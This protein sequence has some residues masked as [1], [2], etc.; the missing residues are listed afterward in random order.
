MILSFLRRGVLSPDR[1]VHGLILE[2]SYGR[3]PMG[4]LLLEA[5]YSRPPIGG[6]LL[7]ASNQVPINILSKFL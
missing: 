7:E 3:P 4:G 5:S 1:G 6:L 2:A